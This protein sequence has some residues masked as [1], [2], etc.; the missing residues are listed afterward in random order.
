MGKPPVT[1]AGSEVV[2]A[3]REGPGGLSPGFDQRELLLGGQ[4]VQRRQGRSGGVDRGMEAVPQLVVGSA[5]VMRAG[6]AAGSVHHDRTG[7]GSAHGL[8][9]PDEDGMA[10]PPDLLPD[11]LAFLHRRCFGHRMDAGAADALLDA[12][13]TQQISQRF[14]QQAAVLA[15]HQG[16]SSSRA[17]ESMSRTS[18]TLSASTP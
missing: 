12:V 15:V 17:A 5:C 13:L 9:A 14:S 10:V 18:S 16:T 6:E 3:Q 2:L 11:H 1:D 7:V 8:V 4:L